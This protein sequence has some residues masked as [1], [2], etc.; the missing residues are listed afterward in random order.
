MDGDSEGSAELMAE[1]EQRHQITE[2]LRMAMRSARAYGTSLMV[3][4]T[5][6]APLEE[7]LVV[8][9]IRPGD[10]TAI[11]VFDRYDADVRNRENNME[12]AGY[13]T[14]P[15]Y[16]LSPTWG[17]AREIHSSR[18]LRFDAITPL[19]DSSWYNYE[20]DWGVSEFVPVI[21]PLIQDQ[22]LASAIAHMSQ[23][24]SIPVLG[25]SDLRE[26]MAGTAGTH[27]TTAAQIGSDINQIKSVFHMMMIDK[28]REDFS[29]V[30]IQF[31]G[32]ANLMDRFALRVA[33][34]GDIPATRFMG[35]SPVGMNATG[36]GDMRNYIMMVE[37]NRENQLAEN[38]PRLDEVLARDAGLEE[39][40]DYEW[41]SL[42]EMSDKEKAE[43]AKVKVDT[44]SIALNDNVI[45]EVEYRR[46]LDGDDIFGLLPEEDLPEEELIPEPMPM[47]L[48]PGPVP[49]IQPVPE[50]GE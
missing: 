18:V 45:S 43:A 25:V 19:T 50:G 16:H 12:E 41:L 14:P 48:P 2:R 17:A 47:N 5:K 42:L 29:R 15:S 34:A 31:G 32:L 27:E 24:A 21:L 9:R 28:D 23:E 44:L 8:E 10:L 7:P 6:E 36:D 39:V 3:L 30:A 46:Q 20:S 1:A 26:L 22:S 35:Q 38:L 33:A 4:V 13:G 49:P 40:P 11:R 37:A